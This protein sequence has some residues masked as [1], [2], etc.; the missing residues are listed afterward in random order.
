MNS[1]N[2]FKY[3]QRISYEGI[4]DVYISD[5]Y[6]LPIEVKIMGEA[7]FNPVSKSFDID[8]MQIRTEYLSGG[9]R[10]NSWIRIDDMPEHNNL[11]AAVKIHL[12]K[13]VDLEKF[14]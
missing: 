5:Q 1:L 6:F 13:T 7:R 12:L 4:L 9:V 3:V 11:I 14:E 2:Q 8:F 10:M